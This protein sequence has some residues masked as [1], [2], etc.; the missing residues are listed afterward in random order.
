MLLL[1]GLVGF[2]IQP[3]HAEV[4]PFLDIPEAPGE[5]TSTGHVDEINLQ[6]WN[7]LVGP[8]ATRARGRRGVTCVGNLDV[9]KYTDLSSAVLS[10]PGRNRCP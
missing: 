10:V 8:D 5:S 3:L 2:S 7:W 1:I 9:S 6:S 4:T